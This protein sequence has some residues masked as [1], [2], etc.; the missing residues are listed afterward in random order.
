[1]IRRNELDRI[2]ILGEYETFFFFIIQT[3]TVLSILFNKII[4]IFK[5]GLKNIAHKIYFKQ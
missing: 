2:D 4:R 1:M 3:G 5:V